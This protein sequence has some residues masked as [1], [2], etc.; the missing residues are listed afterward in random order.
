MTTA[1]HDLHDDLPKGVKHF[2]FHTFADDVAIY[3]SEGDPVL[4][5][6]HLNCDHDLAFLFKWVMFNGFT[7]SI[8]S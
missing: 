2:Y 3:A 8:C 4:V 6:D 7:V 1:I 5:Q